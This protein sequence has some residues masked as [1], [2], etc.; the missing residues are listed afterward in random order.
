MRRVGLRRQ[1]TIGKCFER[2]LQS[3]DFGLAAFRGNLA[4]RARNIESHADF[5]IALLENRYRR[6][7]HVERLDAC[8]AGQRHADISVHVDVDFAIL[9]VDFDHRLANLGA[10]LQTLEVLL[11]EGRGHNFDFAVVE[12]AIQKC[13]AGR[14]RRGVDRLR[15]TRST[16]RDARI[17]QR[18]SGEK[19][20]RC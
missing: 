9:A 18:Y 11:D 13:A 4:H 8:D 5:D 10:A 20:H 2:G 17:I 12:L 3:I 16:V 19:H 1:Q 14:Q 15:H 7:R 6:N